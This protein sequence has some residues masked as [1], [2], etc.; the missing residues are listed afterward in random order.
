MTAC[1]PARSLLVVASLSLGQSLSAQPVAA[2]EA[3]RAYES[4]KC[5]DAAALERFAAQGSPAAQ[6]VL[7]TAYETGGGVA[8]SNQQA[9]AWYKRAVGGGDQIARERLASLYRRLGLDEE[10]AGLLGGAAGERS[11]A[12]ALYQSALLELRPASGRQ[13][14]YARARAL[15]VRA[16]QSGHVAAARE[17]G[18]MLLNGQG[19]SADSEAG[20][21]LLELAFGRGDGAAALELGDYY[22]K[23]SDD[24]ARARAE[25]WYRLA[26]ERGRAEGHLRIGALHERGRSRG[27]AGRGYSPYYSRALEAYKQAAASGKPEI[28]LTARTR[29]EAM[30]RKL[31][32]ENRE[33]RW[34]NFEEQRLDSSAVTY[35]GTPPDS[36]EGVQMCAE[37]NKPPARL[38]SL[39]NRCS[40][41]AS[42]SST[43]CE[44]VAAGWSYF[45]P[46][47]CKRL[48]L[49]LYW[50][51][52]LAIQRKNEKGEWYS[53]VLTGGELFLDCGKGDRDFLIMAE[54]RMGKRCAPDG[55]VIYNA[56]VEGK[57]NTKLTITF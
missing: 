40:P 34:A 23:T 19:G 52:H 6:R 42:A 56:T 22:Q 15:L 5:A 27:L 44:W 47:E 32:S 53:D 17:V 51:A 57:T 31:E 38:A 55:L 3:I 50:R 11:T 1:G 30:A 13:P 16:A 35:N 37:Q 49:G 41:L 45:Q 8:R 21:K 20:I 46:G 18:L 24:L 43:P 36:F 48:R 2:Q 9:I 54:E 10:A 28:V 4:C 25:M 29:I 33:H 12:E 14:D 26:T 39:I 7:A